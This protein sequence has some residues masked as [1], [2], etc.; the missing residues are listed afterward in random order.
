MPR[1]YTHSAAPGDVPLKAPTLDDAISEVRTGDWPEPDHGRL[2]RRD[3]RG[4]RR[5]DRRRPLT[6]GGPA[7]AHTLRAPQGV[8]NREDP[9]R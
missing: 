8:R 1:F 2:R 5:L 7:L 6:P 9:T 4:S 3:P